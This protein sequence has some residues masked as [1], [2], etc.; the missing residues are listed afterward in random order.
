MHHID[1][2]KLKVYELSELYGFIQ[3]L[4]AEANSINSIN[5]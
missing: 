2:Y 1:A 5:S 3:P 4:T